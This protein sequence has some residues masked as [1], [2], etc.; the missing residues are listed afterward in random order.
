MCPQWWYRPTACFT[1]PDPAQ[2]ILGC[3]ASMGESE[4]C[5]RF[6]AFMEQILPDRGD[7]EKCLGYIAY[8]L[9][10]ERNNRRQKAQI[11]VGAGKNGKTELAKLLD[12]LLPG[13][14]GH[15]GMDRLMAKDAR[16]V[17]SQLAGKFVNVGS[18]FTPDAVSSEGIM[19]MKS[20][21]A[22]PL[23]HTE[24]KYRDPVDLPNQC[25]HLYILNEL[26]LAT[27]Y[28]T[29]A[30]WRRWIIIV[31]PVQIENPIP[32]LMDA[33][34][35]DEGPA[36]VAWLVRSW[37]P[38]LD[39]LLAENADLSEDLWAANGPSVFQFVDRCLDLS[40]ETECETVYE[41]Y[42]EFCQK[43][44]HKPVKKTHFGRLVKAAGVE[45]RQKNKTIANLDN[46]GIQS[47][48]RYELYWVYE[49]SLK[50]ID[51]EAPRV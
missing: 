22:D 40:G 23:L 5:P 13:L 41:W 38:R 26:P 1:E 28:M 25:K 47:G 12:Y 10:L 8:C 43:I 45:R 11:W 32:D 18:E 34:W 24:K 19:R 20:L 14:V 37:L 48:N 4:V 44:H 16:F 7:R 31:F 3:V 17:E 42:L 33:I 27:G 6:S 29:Y 39:E 50:G 21:V 46:F 36:I 30:W 2:V 35:Q 51:M 15:V 49:V 9:T